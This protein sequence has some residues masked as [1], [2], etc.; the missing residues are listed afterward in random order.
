M[1]EEPQKESRLSVSV[2]YLEGNNEDLWIALFK[3]C[4]K[5]GMREY[6]CRD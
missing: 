2:E 5:Y 4:V 3:L 1:R 6:S